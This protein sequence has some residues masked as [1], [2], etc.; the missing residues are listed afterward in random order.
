MYELYGIELNYATNMPRSKVTKANFG[1][2][3]LNKAEDE[4]CSCSNES[5]LP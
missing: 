1:D 3:F 5:Q 2:R 4:E